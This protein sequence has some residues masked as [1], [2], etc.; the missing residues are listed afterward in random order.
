[1]C[2][3]LIPDRVLAGLW[4]CQW[5]VSDQERAGGCIIDWVIFKCITANA[6]GITVV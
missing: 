5:K 1:M 4:G 2:G 6:G 3:V